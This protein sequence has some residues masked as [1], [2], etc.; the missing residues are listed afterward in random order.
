ML[1]KQ[2][3]HC[4]PIVENEICELIFI[5]IVF[6]YWTECPFGWPPCYDKVSAYSMHL[7]KIPGQ[8]MIY[9]NI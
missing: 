4:M 5:H 9:T 8:W 1:W 2:S 3:P 7:P 6:G